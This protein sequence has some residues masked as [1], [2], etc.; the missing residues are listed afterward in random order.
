[1]KP[2]TFVDPYEAKRLQLLDFQL[3]ARGIAL[4]QALAN[5]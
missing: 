3:E 2:H 4:Q 5:S 1:M